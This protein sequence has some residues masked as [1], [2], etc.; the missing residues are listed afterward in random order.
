MSIGQG[1]SG[2]D[3]CYVCIVPCDGLIDNRIGTALRVI[4]FIDRF[5][6]DVWYV[7]KCVGS[8]VR[9]QYVHFAQS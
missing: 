1:T 7:C 8:D 9:F 6:C 3:T 4:G 2:A 5:I